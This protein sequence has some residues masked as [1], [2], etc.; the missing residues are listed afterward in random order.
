[1]L[2]VLAFSQEERRQSSVCLCVR[3]KE[4]ARDVRRV[5]VGT[6]EYSSSAILYLEAFKLLFDSRAMSQVA[7]LK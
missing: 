1:M 7:M 5:Q 2:R 4:S 3:K 6:V